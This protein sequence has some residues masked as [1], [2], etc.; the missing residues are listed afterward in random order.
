MM[1][2]VLKGSVLFLTQSR[3]KNIPL[4]LKRVYMF[5]HVYIETYICMCIYLH[6]YTYIYALIIYLNT[7]TYVLVLQVMY[8]I[9]NKNVYLHV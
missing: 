8:I 2:N 9:Y 1:N 3:L 4:S 7:F 6:I 5:M